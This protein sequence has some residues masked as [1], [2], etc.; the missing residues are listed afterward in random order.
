MNKWVCRYET[1]SKSIVT[2]VQANFER[3]RSVSVS[4]EK[5]I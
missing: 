4:N 3:Y 5:H 1:I 2:C